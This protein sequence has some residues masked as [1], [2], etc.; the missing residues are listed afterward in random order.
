MAA[1]R[2]LTKVRKTAFYCFIFT[3]SFAVHFAKP[4]KAFEFI[5]TGK[6]L[7]LVEYFG[8]KHNPFPSHSFAL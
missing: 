7:F 8:V 6:T 4:K 1:T 5:S 2:R 3:Q